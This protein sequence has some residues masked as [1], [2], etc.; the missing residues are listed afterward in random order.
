MK[1]GLAHRIFYLARR[2]SRWLHG[3]WRLRVLKEWRVADRAPARRAHPHRH[4]WQLWDLR[5]P[6]GESSQA[7]F[8]RCCLSRAK[9]QVGHEGRAQRQR[10]RAAATATRQRGG[11]TKLKLIKLQT[12]TVRSRVDLLVIGSRFAEGCAGEAGTL[13]Y[14]R[15]QNLRISEII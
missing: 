8:T 4:T 2:A 10:S 7:T 14:S 12:K 3:A 6:C 13:K 11:A 15:L 9:G 1:D 5:R